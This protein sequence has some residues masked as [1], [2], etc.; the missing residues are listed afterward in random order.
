MVTGRG[1]DE[2]QMCLEALVWPVQ[3]HEC[4][5]VW[6]ETQ[7]TA[8]S[9]S[10]DRLVEGMMRRGHGREGLE[11]SCQIADNTVSSASA[12]GGVSLGW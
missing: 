4:A 11:V 5:G 8:R 1:R 3:D 2:L 7:C 6:R 10:E 12:V 9:A